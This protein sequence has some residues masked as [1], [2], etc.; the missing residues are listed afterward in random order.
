MA[1]AGSLVSLADLEAALSPQTVVSLYD[2]HG[3][4]ILEGADDVTEE[5]ATAIGMTLEELQ[6]AVSANEAG[7]Q[8]QIDLAEA[9][10]NSRL[11]AHFKSL[12]IPVD[13]TPPSNLL[14][15]AALRFLIPFSYMRHP[16]YVKT[17]GENPRGQSL[18]NQAGSFM[19]RICQGKQAMPDVQE[20]DVSSTVGGIV[21]DT[22]PRMMT[23]SVA[24]EGNGGDF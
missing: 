10:V 20:Q 6:T 9:E 23:D 13:Q 8:L 3:V 2:D 7:V 1:A 16:E 5:Q 12:T 17:F 4:G 22:G 14:K 15:L 19:D 18:L 11:Y 21:Y 24:A